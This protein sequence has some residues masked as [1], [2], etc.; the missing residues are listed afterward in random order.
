MHIRLRCPLARLRV[1]GISQ[2]TG[3]CYIGACP[4]EAGAVEGLVRVD[5]GVED[6]GGQVVR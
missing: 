2:M 1:S 3:T 4:G 6:C 5:K